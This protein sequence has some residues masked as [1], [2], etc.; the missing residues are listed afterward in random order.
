MTERAWR[1][2]AAVR[3]A[4]RDFWPPDFAAQYFA[5]A[6]LN[7]RYSSRVGSYETLS[8]RRLCSRRVPGIA[9]NAAIARIAVRMNVSNRHDRVSSTSDSELHSEQDDVFGGARGAA[10]CSNSV[11]S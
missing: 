5:K 11:R 2:G 3:L 8:K 7:S 6:S 9:A 1:A 4:D 10:P